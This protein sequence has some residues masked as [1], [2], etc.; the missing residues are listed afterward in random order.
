MMMGVLPA[1]MEARPRLC[2]LGRRDGEAGCKSGEGEGEPRGDGDVHTG[3]AAS[4]AGA[5]GGTTLAARTRSRYDVRD[6]VASRRMTAPTLARAALE[7][8][9]RDTTLPSRVPVLRA[10]LVA[11][12][13]PRA[14]VA[15]AGSGGA[16]PRAAPRLPTDLTDEAG[17]R[18][19]TELA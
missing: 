13:R 7:A 18:D 10:L 14:L 17:E 1:S 8:V 15:G 19:R 9:P 11:A 2:T 5:G 6:G 3:G 12:S 16:R 4:P